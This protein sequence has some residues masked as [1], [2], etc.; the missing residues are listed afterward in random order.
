MIKTFTLAVEYTDYDSLDQGYMVHKN[1]SRAAA[2]D[3]IK[4]YMTHY[5]N[6]KVSLTT[7]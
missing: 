2:N 3:Y 7:D 1:I 4:Y 6:V 5:H